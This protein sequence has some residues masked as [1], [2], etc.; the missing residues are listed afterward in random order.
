[1]NESIRDALS[2]AISGIITNSITHPLDTMKC[3]MQSDSRNYNSMLETAKHIYH[4][5]KFLGFYKGIFANSLVNV[6]ISSM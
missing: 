1:M 4:N 5:D 6:P 3:M 2:G